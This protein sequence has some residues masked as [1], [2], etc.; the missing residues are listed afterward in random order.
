MYSYSCHKQE[1]KLIEV[2]PVVCVRVFMTEF[3]GMYFCIICS[4]SSFA[5]FSY[6][7][8][9]LITLASLAHSHARDEFARFSYSECGIRSLRSLTHMGVMSSLTSA[10][11]SVAYAR[12]A[13]SLT[14]AMRQG[15][16]VTFL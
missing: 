15:G 4:T 11:P 2:S 8:C 9:G 1:T 14:W 6:S 13:R 16:N 7:E 5:R 12:F 10:T 3:F